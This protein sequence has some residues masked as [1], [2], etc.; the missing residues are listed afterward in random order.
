METFDVNPFDD[1][2]TPLNRTI[3]GW[4]LKRHPSG[5]GLGNALNR[6]IVGWKRKNDN[7]RGRADR[8]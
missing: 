5:I 1:D 7:H 2:A 4:K 3:V 8:L 6:T